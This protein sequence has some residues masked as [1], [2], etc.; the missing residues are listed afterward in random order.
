M[1]IFNR[2][3][4]S[5]GVLGFVIIASLPVLTHAQ[6]AATV[7]DRVERVILQNERE[8]ILVNK[9][10]WVTPH[11][12]IVKLEL[13]LDKKD[14]RDQR[15]ILVW[16]EEWQTSEEAARE[17]YNFSPYP[18]GQ[19]IPKLP[20]GDKCYQ[21]SSHSL[22]LR[23]GNL[24]VRLGATDGTAGGISVLIRFARDIA[25]VVPSQPR[26][27]TNE[28]EENKIEAA[29]HVKEGEAKLKEGHYEQAIEEFKKAIELDPDSA[30]AHY[31]LGVAYLK[32]G[33]RV[34]A[35]DHLRE[36]IRLR[37]DWVEAH[38]SL[39]RAYYDFG[40]YKSAATSFEEA[41][42]LKPDF[43]AAMLELGA[44][45]Q[46]SGLHT[47]SVEVL[48]RAVLL[49][50]DHI[51]A[52]TFLGRALLLSAQPQEAVEVLE[53]SVRLSPEN[54]LAYSMLGE[55]YRS[56]GKFQEAQNAL[57]QALGI[58]PEDPVALN[59]LGMLLQSLER[60]QDAMAAY[61]HAIAVKSDYA[62]AH[63]NLGLLFL[64]LRDSNQ[65][66]RE[67]DI[68]KSL[69]PELAEVLSTKLNRTSP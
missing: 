49:Q 56:L 44:T 25:Y 63:Y 23:T 12:R 31:S 36:A 5:R 37:P 8:W 10:A 35:L 48:R 17:F 55:S 18:E 66:E 15:Q 38:Y 39:A 29:S 54:A 27:T 61:R 64:S 16:M 9:S 40:D 7:F 26:I 6:Y 59:Y 47:K 33:A 43:F 1:L 52:K 2:S 46:H 57:N 51:D 53:Q 28:T 58:S 19:A 67:Y 3:A 69:N 14:I 30:D 4:F 60:Q 45:Y 11:F 65:A 20:I 13:Q 42:R 24:L 34:E 21:L 41:L 68:L 62:E 32:T 50:P 22:L